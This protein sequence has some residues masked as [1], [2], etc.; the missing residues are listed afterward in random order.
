VSRFLDQ[1]PPP[2]VQEH[3]EQAVRYVQ[4]AVGIAME[5]DSDTLPILDHYLRSV[6]ARNQQMVHLVVATAGAYFGEV[7]RRLLGGQWDL[8][9]GDP[10]AWRMVLPTGL[11]FSPA[12]VVAEAIAQDDSELYP[13]AFDAPLRLRPHLEQALARMG[14]VT[15]ETFYSLCGR[16]DTLEHL[17]DVLLAIAGQAESRRN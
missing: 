13:P 16:L 9:A 10:V 3:A 5:Y 2:S 1:A 11:S 12:G 6:P 7:V 17:E 15:V 14:E 4:R 8:S